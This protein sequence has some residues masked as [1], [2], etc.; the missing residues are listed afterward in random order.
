MTKARRTTGAVT[1]K[2]TKRASSSAGSSEGSAQQTRHGS[3]SGAVDHR[4]RD[5]RAQP[6]CARCAR[7]HELRGLD[8]IEHHRQTGFEG[9]SGESL[10][11]LEAQLGARFGERFEARRVV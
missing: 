8:L 1:K 5:T 6:G 11:R 3:D 7:A 9:A 2:A 10:T 4:D